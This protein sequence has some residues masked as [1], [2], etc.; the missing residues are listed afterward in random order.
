MAFP[1]IDR[2]HEGFMS[3]VYNLTVKTVF[4]ATHFYCNTLFPVGFFQGGELV[5]VLIWLSGKAVH[6]VSTCAGHPT[7]RRPS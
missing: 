5:I 3:I 2:G 6:G 4:A 7:A 1:F